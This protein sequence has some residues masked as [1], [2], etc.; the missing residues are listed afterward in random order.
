MKTVQ[1]VAAGAAL[2]AALAGGGMYLAM[3][4]PDGAA[5]TS[6]T[7][8]ASQQKGSHQANGI[9]EQLLTGDTAARVEAA[10]KA[11]HPGASVVR[12][13]T[14][15]EGAAYEAHIRKADGTSATVK[16]DVS[17]NITGTEAG[18]RR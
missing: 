1:N 16:L 7:Q 17:F 13:E 10:A 2:T 14:D 9:T 11:A 12:V 18:K 15:A 8:S 6:T 4:A 5:T 3:A